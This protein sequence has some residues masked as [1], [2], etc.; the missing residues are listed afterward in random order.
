MLKIFRISTLVT[1]FVVQSKANMSW[2]SCSNSNGALVTQLQGKSQSTFKKQFLVFVQHVLESKI[3]KSELVAKAM[4][5][6]DRKLYCRDGNPYVDM[7]QS[8]GYSGKYIFL[9]PQQTLF[10]G[11]HNGE[12]RK[13][14]ILLATISAPHMHAYALELL[15][16][17]LKPN[18]RVL[19]IG[20]GSGY[21]TACFSR[22][23]QTH[24][25]DDPG[26]VIGVEHH[27]KLVEFSIK[28]LNSDDRTFLSEG[29][30][31]IVKS[32][33]RE[34][35]KE[36]APYDAIHVGAAASEVP[37]VLLNQLKPGNRMSI[38]DCII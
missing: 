32:D 22:L 23:I 25:P 37:D 7:P 19:D 16:K 30:V 21:L 13:I 1:V 14:L 17:H 4:K 18:C 34:G 2:R 28:N 15:K 10:F 27:P 6:T 38:S 8:I 12:E 5:E 20:S 9:I 26:L 33:G 11:V 29:K 31:K 3:I 36:F 24:S 35:C